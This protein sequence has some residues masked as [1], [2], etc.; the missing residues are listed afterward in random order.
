M[1]VRLVSAAMS[2][3]EHP[4]RGRAVGRFRELATVPPYLIRY[5]VT[6]DR[7]EILRI[8]HGAQQSWGL[9]APP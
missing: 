7:V 8:K 6:A 1:A 5:Q 4:D 3:S 2:L 9:E